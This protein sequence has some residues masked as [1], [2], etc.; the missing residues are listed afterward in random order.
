VKVRHGERRSEL[1]RSRVMRGG[2]RGPMRSV[3]RQMCRP[4]FERRKPSAGCRC[5]PDQQKGHMAHVAF[6]GR[7]PTPLVEDP[8][9]HIRLLHGNREI[10]IVVPVSRGGGIGGKAGGRSRR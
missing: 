2:P 1:H 9:M 5:S 6:A 4:G 10:S 3:D 7:A 8:G